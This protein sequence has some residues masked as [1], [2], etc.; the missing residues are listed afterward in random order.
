LAKYLQGYCQEKREFLLNGFRFGFKIPYMGPQRSRV[1]RNHASAVDNP[2]IVSKMISEELSKGRI[3]GPFI[4]PP[5]T[6]FQTS[7]IGLVPKKEPGSFRLIHDLSFPHQDSINSEIPSQYSSVQYESL[8]HAIQCIL[9]QGNNCLISKADVESAFRIIPLHS[10][11]FNLLGFCWEGKYY[12]DMCL[13]MGLSISCN[14]FE[15]FSNAI[16]WILCTKLNVKCMSHIL[17]DYIFMGDAHS[18]ACEHG[19]R[20]FFMLAQQVN[21]PIKHSKTCYPTTVAQLHGV[22]VDT[23]KMEARL[24]QDK[25]Q[26]AT[27]ELHR[28]S[29][30]KKT[31]LRDL[32]SS[33]GFL[34]FA[35]KVVVP[36]RPFLRRLFDLTK[37]IA[38]KHY[39]IRISK[40]ARA[41]LSAWLTFI[42]QYNGITMLRQERWISSPCLNLYSDSA[43]TAGFAA[44]LGAKWA[45]G[46]WPD[47]W[48]S[49]HISVLEMY[50]IILALELWGHLLVN[51]CIVFHCDNSAVVAIV[52][53]QTASDKN[54]MPLVRRLV[55]TTMT[56]NI[57]FVAKHI[58]GVHNVVAD[59]IS[60]FQLAEARRIAPWLEIAPCRVPHHL[61]P[62]NI[63]QNRF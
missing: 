6:D 47:S 7:P 2:Q 17:D 52:I 32:Q 48:N 49:F 37:G 28:L 46:S 55:I 16:Q 29:R 23:V 33:L 60:R 63:L 35:C 5:F 8:D 54:I 50:P 15:Q 58:P 40:S 57:L 12:F 25:L 19:L 42:K 4:N 3:A 62:E 18:D 26:K 43:S 61:R 11:S 44:V 1:A 34:N 31:T 56:R 9:S 22:E 51:K 27:R 59:K 13:P 39:H 10:S 30:C 45:Y 41:D 24:P 38:Q 21:I 53:K 36:G 14:I 20:Q